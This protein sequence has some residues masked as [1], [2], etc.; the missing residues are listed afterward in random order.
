MLSQWTFSWCLYTLFFS[1]F[2]LCFSSSRALRFSAFSR[3]S[4]N[5]LLR[6]SN[7]LSR[8][9]RAFSS[10]SNHWA[11]LAAE[12]NRESLSDAAC[13]ILWHFLSEFSITFH[14]NPPQKSFFSLSNH[15]KYR[16][17]CFFIRTD[18]DKFWHIV[19]EL[20]C[21]VSACKLCLICA[22][23]SRFRWDNFSL[24]KAITSI[25]EF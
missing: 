7:W 18:L 3:W 5:F 8:K 23:F 16:W 13:C 24:Q 10:F 14:L 15:P 2:C 9:R 20:F 25:E 6:S 4:S 22:Y 11:F 1:S 12:R 17:V 21:S 19:L